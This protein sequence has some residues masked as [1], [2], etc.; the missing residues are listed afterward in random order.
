MQKQ[1][2]DAFPEFYSGGNVNCSAG[3]VV[4]TPAQAAGMR[5][6]YFHKH[7]YFNHIM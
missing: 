5:I 3:N 1:K 6:L 7:H 2:M 4:S